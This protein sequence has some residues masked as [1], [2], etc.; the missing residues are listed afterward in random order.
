MSKTFSAKF[1]VNTFFLV[2][3]I[4]AGLLFLLWAVNFHL[5]SYLLDR[6]NYNNLAKTVQ[7]SPDSITSAVCG[8]TELRAIDRDYVVEGAVGALG[9]P[10]TNSHV[11][12]EYSLEGYKGGDK[13]F[14]TLNQSGLS[15][16]RVPIFTNRFREEEMEIVSVVDETLKTDQRIYLNFNNLI[17][18]NLPSKKNEVKSFAECYSKNRDSLNKTLNLNLYA[19][20][21]SQL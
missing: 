19:F 12:H 13:Q 11:M 4:I 8:D 6:P 2:A 7:K 10:F 15:D 16:Y 5:V 21:I 18:S 1:I 9:N 17:K 20:T 3:F 14:S